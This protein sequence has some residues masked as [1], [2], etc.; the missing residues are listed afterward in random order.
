MYDRHLKEPHPYTPPGSARYR[1][2]TLFGL[3]GYRM[4]RFRPSW[5]AVGL[6]PLKVFWRPQLLT[7]LLFEG[8]MFG[9]QIG[10]HVRGSLLHLLHQLTVRRRRAA[11]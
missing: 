11:L 3:T 1:I 10:F 2:E 4:A 5:E 6:A 8:A 7:A 9:F